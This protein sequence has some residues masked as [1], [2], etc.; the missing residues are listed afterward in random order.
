MDPVPILLPRM[1]VSEEP[2]F[3]VPRV[4]RAVPA[5][6]TPDAGESWPGLLEPSLSTNT[7]GTPK[8]IYSRSPSGVGLLGQILPLILPSPEPWTADT[9]IRRRAFSFIFSSTDEAKML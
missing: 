1:K 2:P 5:Q 8:G 4:R 6:G 7:V 9:E 3:A